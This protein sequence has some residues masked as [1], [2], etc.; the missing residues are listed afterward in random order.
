MPSHEEGNVGD[1]FNLVENGEAQCCYH[2]AFVVFG[3]RFYG[4]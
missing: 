3:V 4:A 1:I 2:W